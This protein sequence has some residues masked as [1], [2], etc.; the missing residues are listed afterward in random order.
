MGRTTRW[1]KGLFGSSSSS[2]KNKENSS[3]TA[4]ATT[5]TRASP[6]SKNS[7]TVDNHHH[8]Y[9][10]D[11]INDKKRWSFAKTSTTGK[12]S[13]NQIL[14][15]NIIPVNIPEA[16]AAWLRSFYSE[17]N[18][19]NQQNK[20]A[21][22]VAAAT[23][24]AAD[25]AVAA[26]QAAVAVVRL[27]SHGRGGSSMFSNGGSRE[28][29]A[30]IKIQ[31]LFRGFLARKA[32]RAL[33]GLVKLQAVVRGYLVRKQATATLYSM[34]ALIRAQN[35]VRSQQR[36]RSFSRKDH[37]FQPPIRS[38]YSLDD[39][40][41]EYTSSIHSRRISSSIETTMNNLEAESPKIVEIDTN[42]RLKS[43]SRTRRPNVTSMSDL[44][45][46]YHQIPP[47]LSIPDNSRNYP[48]NDWGFIREHQDYMNKYSS[49]TAQSTPRFAYSA[50]FSNGSGLPV[51]PAKSVCANSHYNYSCYPSYMANTQSFRA[52][53]RSS[54]APKQRPSAVPSPRKKLSLIN[55][56][57]V[58]SRISLSSN[59]KMRKSC[60]QVQ[61]VLNF[62]NTVMGNIGL[63]EASA[64]EEEIGTKGDGHQGGGGD[65]LQS[66]W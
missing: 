60:S 36:T 37:K 3:S 61:D 64:S 44:S 21:I 62:K 41:S 13:P 54:S 46:E 28:K 20:H 56:D 40:R 22:A 10:R 52:K 23:A 57:M 34:Q 33:K 63:A 1:F 49:A 42:Y 7:N 12:E 27:T 5:P 4:S 32:L 16:E 11:R 2:S 58:E 30:V 50:G 66:R 39:S 47:R 17:N 26:A 24:A 19:Q 55:N 38:R 35:T 29:W 31:S 65:Y 8:H 6:M 14:Q 45:E 59:V 53:V 48:E 51:T 9:Q 15:N 43:S 25:A 18:D